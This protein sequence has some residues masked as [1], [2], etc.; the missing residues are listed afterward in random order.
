M[1]ENTEIFNTAVSYSIGIGTNNNGM[2]D[3]HGRAPNA[4]DEHNSA[5]LNISIFLC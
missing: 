1:H 5:T 4:N 2:L 3:E